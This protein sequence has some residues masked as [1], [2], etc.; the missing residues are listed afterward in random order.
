MGDLAQDYRSVP[1]EFVPYMRDNGVSEE[2]IN[3]LM[4]ENPWNAYSR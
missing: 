3:K 4:H 1:E 2:L